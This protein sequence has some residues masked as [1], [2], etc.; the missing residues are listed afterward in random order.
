MMKMGDY[1]LEIEY[2]TSSLIAT[3]WKERERLRSLEAE[4][5]SLT[6]R[7]EDNYRRAEF[8][9]TNAEDP[10]DVAMATGM[11]WENYFGDDKERYYKDK[12]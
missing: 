3:I 1:L 2:A 6:K 11:Y 8:V 7:A 4:V 9:A 10:D 5:A 12:D